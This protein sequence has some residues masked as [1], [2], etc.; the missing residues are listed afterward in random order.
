MSLIELA[1]D[2]LRG[3][4]ELKTLITESTE[5]TEDRRSFCTVFLWCAR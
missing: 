4:T 1:T 5:F 2:E 3:W